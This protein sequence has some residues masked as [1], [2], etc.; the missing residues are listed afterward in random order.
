M[1][2]S[3]ILFF[4][5]LFFQSCI[6]SAN[7]NEK[8]RTCFAN[9]K[10]AILNCQGK[11]GLECVDS[12]TIDYYSRTLRKVIEFDSLQIENELPIDKYTI[13]KIRQNI[14]Y[15]SIIH[16][17]GK[18]LLES[19]IN[20]GMAGNSNISLYDIGNIQIANDT[21]TVEKII[22]G[23]ATQFVFKFYK[24][25]DDWKLSIFSPREHELYNWGIKQSILKSKLSDTEYILNYIDTT[26]K[27]ELKKDIW[28]P[29]LPK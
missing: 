23:K 5:V 26:S 2:K 22:G 11:I 9:Y 10:K 1:S 18:S 6:F 8:I 29:L 28:H 4:I 15:D 16:L 25:N 19:L 20:H 12:K 7:D 14:P 27:G 24:E 17:D 13:L 21:A 3:A